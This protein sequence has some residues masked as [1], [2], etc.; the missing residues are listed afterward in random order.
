[1]AENLGI[2]QYEEAWG[3][4]KNL[5]R[6]PLSNSLQGAIFQ[7]SIFPVR[8]NTTFVYQICPKGIK[9]REAL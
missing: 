3:R 4:H 7:V 9:E 5:K 6:R 2:I 8:R 1:M